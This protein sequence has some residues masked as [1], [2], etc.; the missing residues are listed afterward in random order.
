MDLLGDAKD[1]FAELDAQVVP[2]IGAALDP[3]APSRT[4]GRAAEE[5]VEDVAEGPEPA[6]E[7]VEPAGAGA[8][9]AGVSEHVVGLAPLAVRK[10]PIG[11]VELLEAILRSIALVD[12]G[13]MALRGA[14]KR[15]T[16]LVVGGAALDAQDLVV[17]ALD[18]HR[19]GIIQIGT[20]DIRVPSRRTPAA[21]APDQ[22]GAVPVERSR[23]APV[24][25]AG[26][27]MS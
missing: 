16:D 19:P 15:T 23:L 5:G 9:H 25:S 24:N 3:A 21:P 12:V 2:Q 1:R 26:V 20:P 27:E 4:R 13:V 10:D 14:T 7:S 17:V 22:S 11:L 6:T 8:V 18:R